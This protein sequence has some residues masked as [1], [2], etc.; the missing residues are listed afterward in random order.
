[1]R[2]VE[3]TRV[4][5][6]A[7]EVKRGAAVQA[8]SGGEDESLGAGTDGERQAS[9][10]APCNLTLPIYSCTNVA[11]SSCVNSTCMHSTK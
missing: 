9:E 10:C 1:M 3:W 4:A 5:V 7:R 11:C 6:R 2:V 8:K